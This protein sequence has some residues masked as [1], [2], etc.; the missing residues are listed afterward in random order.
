MNPVT[1]V[2]RTL[3]LGTEWVFGFVCMI[4]GLAFLS[5]L[6]ILQFLS[7]GYLLES[8]ARIAR[9]GRFRDGFIG[10][11]MAAR[12]GGIV[13]SSWLL[14]LPTRLLGE[15]AR[16]AEIIDPGSPQAA[17]WRFGVW[18]LAIVTLVHI[19]LA[20]ARGG[21]L[22]Y[23]LW[24]F[25]FIWVLVA[26]YRGGFYTKSRDAVW[27]TFMSLD[28]LHYFWLGFRGFFA[29][30]VWLAI[31]VSLL[32]LGRTKAPIAP[33][34]GFM[35]AFLL[36][37]VLMYLPFLQM[38]M[39]LHN[40][41]AVAFHW[42]GARHAYKRAPWAFT[43][44]FFITLLFAVPLYLFKIEAAPREAAWLPGLFFISFIWPARMLTGWALGRSRK[45][46]EPRHW[47]FR[48][49]GRVPF[50]PIAGLYVLIVFFTQYTSWNG[51][52]SLYEQHAFLLPVPFVGG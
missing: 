38:R 1:E 45:R 50:I 12:L 33:L 19:A 2:A 17:G 29:A 47:F 43:F 15:Y 49:T 14:I 48:L 44:A 46:R 51:V 25:N 11:R 3:A 30:F 23:F 32:A 20:V 41:L 34:V 9:T 4:G 22:R 21:K 31:P 35:G 7:L 13:V 8:G 24:P 16:A 18:A 27:D 39:A 10:I 6:P 28:L 36:A 52:W 37:F 40:R 42:C 5:A 26:V